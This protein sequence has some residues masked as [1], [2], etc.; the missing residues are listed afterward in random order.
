MHHLIKRLAAGCIVLTGIAMGGQAQADAKKIVYLTPSL[1]VS[2]WNYVVSGIQTAGN[3]SG[4]DVITLDSH[5]DDAAQLRN[6][7]AA[8]AMGVSGIVI[9]PTTSLAAPAVLALAEAAGI[10]VVVC[11][12]G[13]A[14]GTYASFVASDNLRGARG[15]G[16]ATATIVRQRGWPSG[17]F[18][19]IGIPQ[20]R[21]NGQLRSEGFRAAMR[22]TALKTE[23]PIHEMKT[24]TAEEV[25]T[26]ATEMMAADPDLHVIFVQSDDQAI[27]VAAAVA[28]AHRES[29]I[30]IAAF[31]GTPE[32][33]RMIIDGKLVGAGMQQPYLLGATSV[34]LLATAI[35]GGS[36]PKLQMV[37]ILTV[38]GANVG[39]KLDQI[40]TNVF[41]EKL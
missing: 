2:F 40:K 1:D 23:I 6:A 20:A 17:S 32:L 14:G 31:D 41:A 37:P 11:D 15:I 36:P 27:P 10:P 9:S 19:M 3:D 30:L 12:I 7:Q 5:N 21:K 35:S 25:S 8:I 28:A 39:E 18:G 13:T 16:Q 33:L 22:D 38:T 29:D 24:F 34:K 4:Y 26:Y